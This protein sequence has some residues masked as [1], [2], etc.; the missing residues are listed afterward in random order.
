M[1]RQLLS[2]WRRSEIVKHDPNDP[3]DTHITHLLPR[4]TSFVAH[5]IFVTRLCSRRGVTGHLLRVTFSSLLQMLRLQSEP[6]ILP[7]VSSCCMQTRWAMLRPHGITQ[8]MLDEYANIVT[9]QKNKKQT[10]QIIPIL[11]THCDW[12]CLKIQSLLWSPTELWEKGL[13]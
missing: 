3:H 7:R 6:C 2:Q 1:I 9:R 5:P 12:F 10:Q 4:Y 8:S 13:T 11:L